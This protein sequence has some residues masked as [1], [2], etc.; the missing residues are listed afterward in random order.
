[1]YNCQCY[2]INNDE[3]NQ[4][5]KISTDAKTKWEEAQTRET[6]WVNSRPNPPTINV[7]CCSNRVTCPSGSRCEGNIQECRQQIIQKFSQENEAQYQQKELSNRNNIIRIK[8]V[9]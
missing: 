3:W 9:N 6:N 7:Q 2:E 5:Y 8:P 4:N 1:M